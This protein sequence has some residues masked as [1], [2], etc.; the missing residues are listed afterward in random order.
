MPQK[1]LI[2]ISLLLLIVFYSFFISDPGIYLKKY[3]QPDPVRYIQV[4]TT[5]TPEPASNVVAFLKPGN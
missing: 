4:L 3:F 2:Q 1:R 5:A